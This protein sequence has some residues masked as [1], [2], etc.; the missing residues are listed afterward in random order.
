[1]AQLS[2]YGPPPEIFHYD[3]KAFYPSIPHSLAL[4]AFL[5]FH[6]SALEQHDLLEALLSFN[7]II[8]GDIYYHL[9]PVGIPMG[10][11]LAPEIARMVTA[12]QLDTRQELDSPVA[13]SL[14]FDNLYTTHDPTVMLSVF[15]PFTLTQEHP[16][17]F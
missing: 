14:Y 15:D 5:H 7:F 16:N 2:I 3:I 17:T 1:M 6:P 13:Y 11:P 8:S 4:E 12:Y 9:G 10:L